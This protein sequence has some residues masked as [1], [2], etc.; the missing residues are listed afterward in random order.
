[1]DIR[2]NPKSTV[3][4][5][6]G[7]IKLPDSAVGKGKLMEGVR[8]T[9]SAAFQAYL[10]SVLEGERHLG[11]TFQ[12]DNRGAERVDLNP[13]LSTTTYDKGGQSRTSHM[14]FFSHKVG[15]QRDAD[16]RPIMGED[17][18]PLLKDGPSQVEQIFSKIPSVEIA[19]N[20]NGVFLHF[21]CKAPVMVLDNRRLLP[22]LSELKGR[23]AEKGM[24]DTQFSV[25]Q[26]AKR[27]AAAQRQAAAKAKEAPA[28][29]VEAEA[30]APA[31]AAPEMG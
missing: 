17:G 31:P 20:G 21:A 18:K 13:Y 15:V 12:K 5:L 2:N 29:E 25:T 28:K 24:G 23:P 4:P 14:T 16:N 26:E 1:M 30:E 9:D 11:I 3:Y 6:M 8:K 22:V 27:A 19:R 7:T 10:K